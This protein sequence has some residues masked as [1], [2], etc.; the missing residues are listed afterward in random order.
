MQQTK[1]R[2]SLR[3]KALEISQDYANICL[4]LHRELSNSSHGTFI[5]TAAVCS[6]SE[7]VLLL[8]VRYVVKQHLS[9]LQKL[10][11]NREKNEV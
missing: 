1:S 8:H 7:K 4:L 11:S 10:M 5:H 6:A 3:K 2:V 9:L